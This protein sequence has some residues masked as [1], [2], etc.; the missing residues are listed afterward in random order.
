MGLLQ[1]LGQWK[2]PLKRELRWPRWRNCHPP[3]MAPLLA[4]PTHCSCMGTACQQ[5]AASQF[6]LASLAV[7]PSPSY[8]ASWPKQALAYILTA[9]SREGT[10]EDT[11]GCC[12]G[13]G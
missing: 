6:P 8:V 5:V 9:V 1:Q 13:V 10:W 3:L 11:S 12:Q 4:T 7:P 2:K